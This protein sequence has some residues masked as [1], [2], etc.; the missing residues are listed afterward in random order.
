MSRTMKGLLGVWVAVLLGAAGW[1]A[2]DAWHGNQPSIGGTFALTDQNGRCVTGLPQSSFNVFDAKRAQEISFFGEDDSP[3]SV[4]IVFDLTG[5]M[6]EEK[7]RP[8][9]IRE[10]RPLP[11]V[12]L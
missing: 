2:W 7:V 4:G 6:T 9:E 5:S 3:I 12:T 8:I 11:S 10:L 1:I